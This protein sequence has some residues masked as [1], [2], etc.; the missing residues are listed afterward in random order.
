MPLAAGDRVLLCTD[1]LEPFLAS[2]PAEELAAL[3]SETLLARAMAF[4][5][6]EGWMDDRT[7]VLI[8]ALH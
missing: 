7:A 8:T 4:E 3:S 5:K 6:A 2:L 1:G